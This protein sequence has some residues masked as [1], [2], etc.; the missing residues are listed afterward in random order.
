MVSALPSHT[1]RCRMNWRFLDK[2]LI[3]FRATNLLA[4]SLVDMDN[5]DYRPKIS[6]VSILHGANPTTLTTVYIGGLIVRQ[7]GRSDSRDNA[8]LGLNSLMDDDG[9]A[10]G[11]YRFSNHRLEFRDI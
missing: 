4:I 3:T 7:S 8:S 2:Y 11:K 5:G 10:F 1:K 9:R 6:T